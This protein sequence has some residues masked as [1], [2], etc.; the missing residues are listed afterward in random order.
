MHRYTYPS[1][2]TVALECTS[3]GT[4]FAA[5]KI[6]TILEPITDIGVI[7][8]YAE[9]MFFHA[10]NCKALYGRAFQIQIEVTSGE[11]QEDE[12]IPCQI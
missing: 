1:T 4:H 2:F 3:N 11:S 10:A 6:T 12:N 7:R 5:E 9:K 8:C